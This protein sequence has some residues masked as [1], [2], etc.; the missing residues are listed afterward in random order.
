MP[1]GIKASLKVTNSLFKDDAVLWLLRHDKTILETT[2]AKVRGLSKLNTQH[3]TWLFVVD[4]DNFRK[5][6]SPGGDE[7]LTFITGKDAEL[8]CNLMNEASKTKGS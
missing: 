3:E 7:L 6:W 8:Y 2:M 4:L 5:A 1:F